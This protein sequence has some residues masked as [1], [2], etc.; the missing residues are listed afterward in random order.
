MEFNTESFN[1]EYSIP[2]QKSLK[3]CQKSLI[4]TCPFK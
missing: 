3:K 1:Q 4:E 2:N